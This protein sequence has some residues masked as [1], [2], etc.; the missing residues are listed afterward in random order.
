MSNFIEPTNI[1]PKK[2]VDPTSRYAN[3]TTKVVY[4]SGQ[5]NKKVLT[6]SIY[7]RSVR[8]ISTEDK[9]TIVTSATEYRPDLISNSFYG[10]P[11]LWW[12]IMEYNGI[13]DIFDFKAGVNIRLPQNV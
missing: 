11:H 6:F 7:K 2:Y 8:A 13:Y 9:F 10:F 4:Y 1:S 5:S 3:R 12:K